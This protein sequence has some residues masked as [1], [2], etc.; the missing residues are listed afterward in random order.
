MK[1]TVF[2]A[3]IIALI[4]ACSQSGKFKITGKTTGLP[5]NT[6]AYL[7]RNIDGYWT[8]DTALIIGNRFVFSDTAKTEPFIAFLQIGDDGDPNDVLP[9]WI[10]GGEVLVTV[11]DTIRN[12]KIEKSPLNKVAKQWNDIAKEKLEP[13]VDIR[14]SIYDIEDKIYELTTEEEGKGISLT[15]ILKA[16]IDSLN[17]EKKILQER[18]DSLFIDYKDKA[19]EFI[20]SHSDS[21]FSL[22][23][24]HEL[25]IE[26]T[27]KAEELFNKMTEKLRN[28]EAGREIFGHIETA[29]IT[30]VGAIAP[31]FT[32]NTPDGDPVSL[33]DFRGKYVLV[34]FWASWCGPCRKEN[35][36]VVKAYNTFKDKNFTVL[37]VSLD[38]GEND[39]LERWKK[40]IAD[41]GLTWTQ[42]SD[43]KYWENEAARLYYIHSIPSNFLIDPEGKIVA[44]NLR[45]EALITKLTEILK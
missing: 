13:A 20:K 42:V 11:S 19:E 35:P 22:Q 28:T 34:D 18:A 26:E 25:F 10:E 44:K 39:G 31:D 40:A 15:A 23:M 12:S 24:I 17:A 3:L 33:S 29:R 36:T 21:Y 7:H 5:D 27:D 8:A 2:I 4:A 16:R 1:K 14:Q 30:A 45:G 6:N 32:Q 41:D 43:L 38:S 37:G 9:I